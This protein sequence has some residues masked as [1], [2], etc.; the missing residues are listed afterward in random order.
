MFCRNCGNEIPMDA[1]FACP[2]CNS[3][4]Q[5]VAPSVNIKSHL[6]GAILATIFCCIPFGVVAIVYA[7]KVSGL[8][9]Q[10]RIAEAEAASKSASTWLWL[11]VGLGIAAGVIS[12]ILNF[13]AAPPIVY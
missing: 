11:S 1:K 7:S 4:L 10:G 6:V 2:N 3:P 13:L 9:A 5:P 8:V 12:F